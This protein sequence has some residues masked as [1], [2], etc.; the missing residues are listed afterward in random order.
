VDQTLPSLH[1]VVL[2]G[3]SGTRFWPLSREL[4]PKQIL[5]V[6]GGVSLLTRS[7]RRIMPFT[8]C[9]AVH[10]VTGEALFD[11]LRN[12]LMAQPELA[13]LDIDYMVEPSGR[14]TAPALAL[15]AALLVAA[16]PDAVLVM[17]PSDHLL[18]DGETWRNTIRVAAKLASAGRLVTIG[19]KPAHPETGYG[20]IHA[21]ERI[22][23]AEAGG[24]AGHEVA[25]FI[26]KPD[27]ARAEAFVADGSYLW[28]SGMLVARATT[29]LAELRRCGDAARTPQSADGRR[30]ADV[31]ERM[32]AL[33]RESWL[34]DEGRAL[35]DALP[36]VP[37]DKAVLEVSDKVA[38]VPT[39]LDWSDVGSLQAVEKLGERDERGNVLVG[40]VY[41]VDSHDVIAYS[42][43]RLVATLGLKD[44]IV[45]DTADATLVVAKDRTQDVRLI[46]EALKAVGAP[47]VVSSRSSLRPWGSWTMLMKADGFQIKSIDVLPGK[48][49]SVQS[50]TR[51]S[52]HW[53]VI[54][55]T[56]H[57]LRDGEILEVARNESVYLPIGTV[58]RMENRGTMPLKVV[59]VAVGEY[60]GEDDIVRYE[61]DYG[62]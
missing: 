52:E 11:E 51:S 46:V 41:D 50:H 33:P 55:G 32:A 19:L 7:I 2:A 30:I 59:E 14:N 47:E 26:E 53:I 22:P 45:V 39:Q 29:V 43:D 9:D 48:R 18:E 1:A 12:H 16:D 20:Y 17:L 49:L 21:A 60:L 35:Y 58:H 4:S 34:T 42:A 10:V 23:G 61:D 6:F 31:C 62:R 36:S 5:S 8:A 57:V 3:G 28:N 40:R 56:A 15:A 13:H 44:V 24:I 27:A 25:E 38:V 54:E 37:F